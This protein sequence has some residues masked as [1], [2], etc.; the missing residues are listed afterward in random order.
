MS[1]GFEYASMPKDAFVLKFGELNNTLYIV[2]GGKVSV[3]G[4]MTDA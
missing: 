3:W 1:N 2:L 4:P